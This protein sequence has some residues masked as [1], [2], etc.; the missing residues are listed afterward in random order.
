MFR[1]LAVQ[2]LLPIL[3]LGL[4]LAACGTV[5]MTGHLAPRQYAQAMDSA[6]SACLRNP[7][8]YAPQPGEVAVLPWLSRSISASRTTLTVL[9]LLEAADL[10]RIE[11]VLNDCANQASHEVNERLL[12]KGQ[13][14]TRQLCQDTFTTEPGGSKVTWAMHLGREKHQ[15][16]LE[17]VQRE[18]GEKFAGNL[19]LQPPYRYNKAT[20]KLETLDRRQVDE[21]LRE[22][23][24]GQLL[25]T[26]IPDVVVHAAGDLTR[27]QAV[28][29]FKF[30][31]PASNAP[32]W[33][34][35]HK[36]HPFHPSNQ[37]EIYKEAFKVTP[38][39]VA[40]GYGGV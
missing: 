19:S 15:A 4:L 7:A 25:G 21:W 6:T 13:R 33:R 16:A 32:T 17:C 20:K 30:P 10:A 3:A 11:Q 22:G 38:K 27:I 23:L 18:L 24:F 36:D 40:P 2:R 5:R 28:F 35:Y 8:C 39:P 37:G 26:L 9:R 1:C 34:E 29:D 31:C 12:G 14:P